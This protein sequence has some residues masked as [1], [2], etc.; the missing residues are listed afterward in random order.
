[1][2]KGYCIKVGKGTR[3]FKITQNDVTSY[4]TVEDRPIPS[5][6]TSVSYKEWFIGCFGRDQWEYQAKGHPHAVTDANAGQIAVSGD[7]RSLKGL[8]NPSTPEFKKIIEKS[9]EFH[10]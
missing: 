3:Y 6:T 5:G 8:P 7:G 4:G 9:K 1:M 2:K 10:L